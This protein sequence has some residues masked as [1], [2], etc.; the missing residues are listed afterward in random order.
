M[1]NPS[2]LQSAG[3]MQKPVDDQIDAY[4]Q[5]C[6]GSRRPERD[7]NAESDCAGIF[8]YHTAPV[9][10]GGLDSQTQKA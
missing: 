1:V 7:K 8:P 6:N 4:G 5:E 3:M 2:V 9:R 10:R